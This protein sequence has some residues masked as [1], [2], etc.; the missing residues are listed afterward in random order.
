MATKQRVSLDD[1]TWLHMDGVDNPMVVN[2]LVILGGRPDWTRVVE[3]F[4]DRVVGVFPRFRQ[5]VTQEP[6]TLGNLGGPHW[7][8]D[9]AFSL[10]RHVERVQLGGD[11]FEASLRSHLGPEVAT[12]LDPERPRWKLQLIDGADGRSAMLLRSHHSMADGL[13]LV[14]VLLAMADPPG[15]EVSHR[16][17]MPVDA[18]DQGRSAGQPGLAVP[19]GLAVFANPARLLD[20][21]GEARAN[22]K[23][24]RKL[25]MLADQKNAMRAPLTGAKQ[26][27]WSNAVDLDGVKLV[28]EATGA[29]VNDVALAIF[30]GALH[31]YFEQHGSIP[32]RVGVT[33]PFNLR[34]LDAPLD[35]A[36]GN[37][38][39]LVFINLPVGIADPRARLD[40]IRRR[41]AKIKASPE[42]EVVRGGMA[43]VGAVPARGM[44]K[45][46]ME[47]FTGKCTAIITNIIGPRAPI[48][49]GGVPVQDFMLWVPTSGSIG[50]GLSIV[51]YGDQLRFGVQ[52]D[53]GVVTDLDRL[54]AAIDHELADL[55]RFVLASRTA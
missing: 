16:G 39:G 36:L 24:Y 29:T 9:P 14:Q 1:A 23:V 8:D 15:T 44:A 30:A 12:L 13:A 43:M 46:W 41:M 22:L 10:D 37:Q 48:S 18:T 54:L 38:L 28:A 4:V 52:V 32:Y 5:R 31:R 20:A 47:L 55:D 40:H 50:V 42:G 21:A 49:L 6:P 34:D 35:P 51:T 2:T 11:D 45:A 7:E 19:D 25:A 33:I 53:E 17:Q 3:R 26:L 27:G